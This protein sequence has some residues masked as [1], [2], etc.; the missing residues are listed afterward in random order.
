MPP[1]IKEKE[2]TILRVC[3]I[4]AER[5]FDVSPDNLGYCYVCQE[6]VDTVETTDIDLDE[7]ESEIYYFESLDL[8][9]QFDL[10]LDSIGSNEDKLNK[11]KMCVENEFWRQCKDE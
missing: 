8:L 2:C 6:D 9:T 10:I 11:L 7:I 1:S 3:C 5:I 4:C